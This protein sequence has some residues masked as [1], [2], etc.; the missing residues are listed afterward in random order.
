MRD[1]SF[2][3]RSDLRAADGPDGKAPQ[4][5]P[6]RRSRHRARALTTRAPSTVRLTCRRK[7]MA[8]G[9]RVEGLRLDGQANPEWR[10]PMVTTTATKTAL[11]VR[12]EAKPGK[13]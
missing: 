8:S 9:C 2:G 5:A 13:E 7:R 12:L 6:C 1:R 3:P 10:S 4:R 11:L